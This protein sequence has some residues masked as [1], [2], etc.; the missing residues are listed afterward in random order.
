MPVPEGLGLDLLELL[1][2]F[3]DRFRFLPAAEDSASNRRQL[4]HLAI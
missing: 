1:V 4:S 2:G 3:F